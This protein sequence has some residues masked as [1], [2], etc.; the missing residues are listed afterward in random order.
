MNRRLGDLL[1]VSDMDGTLLTPEKQILPCDIETI[2]LFTSLGGHF[3][4]ATGR[5]V[6][7]VGMY[8]QLVPLVA[9][10]PLAPPNRPCCAW[11][12]MTARHPACCC[13]CCAPAVRWPAWPS[14]PMC[15]A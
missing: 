12:R 15:S 10:P 9:P 2:R 11:P 3:T 4:V 8:P 6:N 14:A 1:V 7:S 5:T 13:P